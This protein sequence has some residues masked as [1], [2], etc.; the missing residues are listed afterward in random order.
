MVFHHSNRYPNSTAR[1]GF[2]WLK[3]QVAVYHLE[4][5]RQGPKAVTL[6]PQSRA[7]RINTWCKLFWFSFIFFFIYCILIVFSPPQYFIFFL[8]KT[9]TTHRSWSLKSVLSWPIAPE[10]ESYPEEWIMHWSGFCQVDTIRD[11]WEGR[12]PTNKMTPSLPI[13]DMRNHGIT[14]SNTCEQVTLACITIS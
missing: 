10:D 14:S 12:T 4:K 5:S 2:H 11:I 7:E 1:K 13:S 3:F 9:K 8:W 6:H